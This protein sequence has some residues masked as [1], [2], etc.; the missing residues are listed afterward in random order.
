[1]ILDINLGINIAAAGGGRY[2]WIGEKSGVYGVKEEYRLFEAPIIDEDVK[3]L[4]RNYATPVT[5]TIV[6]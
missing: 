1:M 6:G 2:R 5:Y 4:Q 3:R